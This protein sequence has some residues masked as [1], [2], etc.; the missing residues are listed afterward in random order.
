MR[1]TRPRTPE[2]YFLAAS[3]WREALAEALPERYGEEATAAARAIL[4]ENALTLYGL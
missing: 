3:W 4:R 1:R 2:L